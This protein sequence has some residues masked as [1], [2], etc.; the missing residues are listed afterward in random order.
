MARADNM[1]AAALKAEL[2]SIFAQARVAAK[3]SAYE[4]CLQGCADD[5]DACLEGCGPDDKKC[6][7]ACGKASRRCVRRCHSVSSKLI[8]ALDELLGD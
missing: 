8:E 3:G 2:R 1:T 5:A 6:V 4:E 7:I